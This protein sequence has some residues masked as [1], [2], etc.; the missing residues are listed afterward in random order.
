MATAKILLDPELRETLRTRSWPEPTP[1]IL[2]SLQVLPVIIYKDRNEVTPYLG[3]RHIVGIQKWDAYAKA[4]YLAKMIDQEQHS[5]AELEDVIGDKRGTIIK[6]YVCYKVIEQAEEEL[7]LDMKNARDRFSLLL[8]SVGNANIKRFL[9]LPR[10]LAKANGNQ[11]IPSESFKN[12]QDFLLW[13]FGNE[14]RQ[15]II[16]DSRQITSSLSHVLASPEAVT[17]LR[18]TNNLL[19]AYERSDGEE[20]MILKYL[21]TANTKLESALSVA[22]RHRTQDVALQI[23]KAEETVK[24]LQKVVSEQDHG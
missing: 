5:I 7:D 20:V 23:E 13:V 17:H 24:Q 18:N 11:P 1:E 12:L 21:A 9:G 6:T 22:H 15:P 10:K 19:D 8:L 16:S 2:E 4:R 14:G 3:V